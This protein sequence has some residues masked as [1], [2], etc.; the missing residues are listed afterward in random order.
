MVVCESG[1]V[2]SN[3]GELLGDALG[4]VVTGFGGMGPCKVAL[5]FRCNLFPRNRGR[6]TTPKLARKLIAEVVQPWLAETSLLLPGL[7]DCMREMQGPDGQSSTEP[8]FGERHGS[9]AALVR[10]EAA[11]GC[12]AGDG[13]D[14]RQLAELLVDDRP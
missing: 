10:T 8:D 14:P 12:G 13:Y 9:A 3:L 2:G 6:T 7:G 1:L 11:M 4:R 5:Q